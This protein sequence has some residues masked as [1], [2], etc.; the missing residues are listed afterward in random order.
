MQETVLP[1]VAD[2]IGSS[3]LTDLILSTAENEIDTW[4]PGAST[5]M[6]HFQDYENEGFDMSKCLYD[7]VQN[8]KLRFMAYKEV[9]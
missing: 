3:S 9:F 6:Q 8:S 7:K 4:K 1:S 5:I 2:Q